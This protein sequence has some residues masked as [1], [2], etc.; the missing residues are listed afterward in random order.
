MAEAPKAFEEWYETR[1][2]YGGF[3]AK[4]TMAGALVVLERLKEEERELSIGAHT[5]EGGSQVKGASGA[6]VKKI[7]ARFDETRRFVSEGGRTNRGLRG[8]MEVML[9][10]LGSLGLE[11]MTEADRVA[12]LE[13][14]QS[15]IVERVREFHSRQRMEIVFDPAES[16]RDLV[17]QMLD[18]AKERGQSGQVAQYL[19]GAKLA[20]RFPELEIPNE[21]YSTADQQLGRAGD[22]VVGDTA[23]HVTMTPADSVYERCRRNVGEGRRAYL[24]VPDE[25]VQG[26]RA[27]ADD[28]VP[29]RVAVEAIESFV[30][31]NVEEMAAFSQHELQARFLALLETYNRRVDAIEIDKSIMVE[32]PPNLLPRDREGQPRR[33]VRGSRDATAQRGIRGSRDTSK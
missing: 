1:R 18:K 10:T 6:A 21:T 17:R 16:T 12:T 22:F 2:K 11:R 26:A 14:C 13:A 3:P 20:L 19:V 28:V 32:I 15:F 27:R 7:L 5:A 8:D 25:H 31:Q 24:L 33:A 9:A 23:F 29:G 4:G 30:G